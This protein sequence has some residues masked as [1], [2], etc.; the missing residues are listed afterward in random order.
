MRASKRNPLPDAPLELSD[1]IT[2]PAGEVPGAQV[3]AELDPEHAVI[4]FDVLR[5]AST[6]AADAG[7]RGW[8]AP[9]LLRRWEHEVLTGT[10]DEHLRSAVGVLLGELV[11]PESSDS[12]QLSLCC[13]QISEW[14]LQRQ[15]VETS[16]EFN[17]LAALVWPSNARLAYVAGRRYGGVSRFKEA[18]IWLRRAARIARWYADWEAYADALT[19]I[20]MLA[21]RQGSI[22][23]ARTFLDRALRVARRRGLRRL[24]GEILHDRFTVAFTSREK[25][26]AE[27]LARGAYERYL[28]AHERLPAL[29]YDVAYYWLTRGY[30]GRALR[31]LRLLRPHFPHPEAQFQVLCAAVRAAGAVGDRPA[32]GALWLDANGLM[33]RARNSPAFSIALIDL[34]YGAA[35]VGEWANAEA[36]FIRAETV[37]RA[38]GQAEDSVRAEMALQ[39]VR[40]RENPDTL[41]P[42]RAA[43]ASTELGRDLVSHLSGASA[44]STE[45]QDG[46]PPHEMGANQ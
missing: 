43:A 14:A 23:R 3:L 8:Y 44:A 27:A 46:P 36:V 21:Y 16:L 30:A 37:A 33:E 41:P 39:A 45:G 11:H 13:L 10:L 22:P 2:L 19:S 28:P 18:D 6:W 20:G 35:H 17:R 5:V 1:P 9:R 25:T 38:K 24:E 7:R 15:A 31:V 34:G 26:D 42:L 40:R 32:F 12:R 4:L 29:A